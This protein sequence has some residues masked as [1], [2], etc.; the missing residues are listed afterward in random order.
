MLFDKIIFGPIKSRRL[1]TSLGVNLLPDDCKLCNFDCIYCECGFNFTKPN[2]HLP[3]RDEIKKALAEKLLEF[4]RKNEHIDT[5]TFAGNGEPT[6]HPQFA[7]IIDDV[8]NLRDTLCPKA[9]V[10]V[11]SNA[12][13]IHKPKVFASLQK[14]DNN[15]LKLDSAIEETIRIVNQPVTNFSLADTIEHLKRFEG[16]IIVQT[17]FFKG[18]YNGVAIDNTSDIE[19]EAWLEALKKIKPCSVM[20]YTLDRPTPAKDLY[21]AD[22]KRLQEISAMVE[23]LGIKTQING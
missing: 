19:V 5:I 15:I 4:A 18:N 6:M 22:E 11:L 8:V 2:S 21:K 13:L 20:I 16:N 3:Q 7:D 9:K 10:S 12:T 14:I 1:G 17:L 23:N